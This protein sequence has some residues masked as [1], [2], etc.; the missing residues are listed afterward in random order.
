M[1]APYSYGNNAQSD[2]VT[3]N[4]VQA[5][6]QILQEED[7]EY[8]F[9]YP[10]NP[11][12][13]AAAQVGIR[14]VVVRQ[15]RVG[16]HMADAV[17]RTTGGDSIGVF[18]MQF[19]PGAEN[20]FP[21]VA[22]AYA[23][24]VPLVV[25]PMGY[26]QSWTDVEPNFT[27][28]HNYREITKSCEI[29]TEPTNAPNAVR[30][31]FNIAR[32]GRPG[33]TLVEFPMDV[34]GGEVPEFT[35]SPTTTV[36]SAPDPN[37]IPE[38]VDVILQAEAPVIHAGQGVNYSQAWP[39]LREFVELLEAPITT[40]LQAKGAFPE[41]HD[42]ALGT[43]GRSKPKPVTKFIEQADVIIGI[44]C[45]FTNTSYGAD[46]PAENTI[47]HATLDP[48][49][50]DK[51]LPADYAL[52]GDAKLTLESLNQHV[53]ST[54]DA[55]SRGRWTTVSTAINEVH[56]E[57]EAEWKSK[58]NAAETPLSPYRIINDLQEVLSDIDH[59]ITHDSG[60]PRDQLIPFWEATEPL[61]Y[62]G[63]GKSTQLGY[64]LGLAMGAKLANPEKLCVNVWG[65]AAIG[66]TGM[67]FETAVR[68]DIPI[69]SILFNNFSMAIEIQY[70]P[71]ASEKYGSTDISG[72]YADMA[73]AFGGY[74]ERI[75]DPDKIVPALERGIETVESGTPALLEFI[76]QKETDFPGI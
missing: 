29:V 23:D 43:G 3:M 57:W 9:T 31:A 19:G 11:I 37:V 55:D 30:R 16:L 72:N 14:P 62:I 24:A 17:S 63:W 76:T 40:S 44:G 38:I 36:R 2:V 46:I 4:V 1:Y 48:T 21:G 51:D 69:L 53:R 22:Q 50:I 67:D 8:L 33:P 35:Y 10:V 64:G 15:E 7:V 6:A 41:D 73:T 70:L 18:C 32:N 42:L 52:V 39:E 74:G 20:A 54:L 12:I 59:I 25:L 47:I 66:M 28:A 68:E 45:S 71:T 34:F 5:V 65:D 49:D 75:E 13:E 26:E 58:L 61:S 60:S 27:A 56:S